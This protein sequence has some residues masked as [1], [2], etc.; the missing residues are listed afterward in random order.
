MDTQ[1]GTES[2]SK[3]WGSFLGFPCDH[4]HSFLRQRI[5]Y[6]DHLSTC[7]WPGTCLQSHSWC[8]VETSNMILMSFM[9]LLNSLLK[10]IPSFQHLLN[11]KRSKNECKIC[12]SHKAVTW[13]SSWKDKVCLT[14]FRVTS[15]SH[16]VLSTT[17]ACS[18]CLLLD[19]WLCSLRRASSVVTPSRS[20]ILN[21][22]WEKMGIKRRGE[23]C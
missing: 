3:K 8:D 10:K 17:L 21:T 5:P 6:E 12:F 20:V 15:G 13:T 23:T 7:L 4:P 9:L 22:A 2:W 14:C 1:S 11:E 19:H 16:S 18:T